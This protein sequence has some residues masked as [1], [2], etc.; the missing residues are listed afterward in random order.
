MV[1]F[2]FGS[3]LFGLIPRFY[4][5]SCLDLFN[6]IIVITLGQIKSNNSTHPSP[7]SETLCGYKL[8]Q[9]NNAM[10]TKIVNCIKSTTLKFPPPV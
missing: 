9:V 8:V 10:F 1:R 4:F 5:F 2:W 7:I 6:P 3:V